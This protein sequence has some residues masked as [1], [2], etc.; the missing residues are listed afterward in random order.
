MRYVT[1][2]ALAVATVGLA[3]CE[4]QAPDRNP[5]APDAAVSFAKGI[6][7][8]CDA[9]RARLIGTQQA[10]LW[11]KPALD[12][13]KAL[14]AIVEASCPTLNASAMLDYIQW[15]IDNRGA[16]KAGT[17]DAQLLTHWN[18]VFPYVGYVGN[19]QP[20]SVPTTIFTVDGAAKVI[21][22]NQTGELTAANAALTAYAQN[23]TG[24]QRDH[25]FVIYPISPNCLTGTNL[26]QSG[27][28]FQ[29]SA[30]PHVDPKF[31]PKVK[32]GICQPVHEN[33]AI[34]LNSPALGHLEPLTRITEPAGTYPACVDLASAV[35]A[36]S[37]HDGIGGVVTRLAWMAKKAVT[38][39]PLYAVHG[40]LGGLGGGLSPFGAADLEV[41]HATFANDVVGLPPGTPGSGTWTQQTKSPGTILVQSALGQYTNKLAVLDQGGGNC[42]KCLGL[43]LQGN[44]FTVGSPATEGVYDAEWISLQDNANMKEA[45]FVLRDT[46]GRDIARVT[47]AVRN[48]VNVILYNDTKTQAGTFVANWVQH[49]ASTFK[50]TVDLDAHTTSLSYNGSPVAAATGVGYVNTNAANLA[51]I[52]ADFRGIDSGVMGWD[53][54]KVTRQADLNH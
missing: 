35:P 29:F 45:V 53:E 43:L 23:A 31:D 44:I 28:C 9:A 30:F 2:A 41:F 47:Y 42:A 1:L 18:T 24:D 6:G 4:Q 25:L 49:V 52:S 27:P 50:I 20:S 36:G 22:G 39:E 21:D 7:G 3:A 15:T 54:I 13:A 51:T 10:D 37:W 33:E 12:E 48:N 16:R 38:P 26:R 19:D 46:G 34:P 17:T 32:V 5:T 40:G 8:Q 14:F 11:A